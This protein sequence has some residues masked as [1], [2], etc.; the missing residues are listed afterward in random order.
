MISEII[1]KKPR[2]AWLFD[3]ILQNYRVERLGIENVIL[4]L[5]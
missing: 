5:D 4:A 2:E 3:I 1:L